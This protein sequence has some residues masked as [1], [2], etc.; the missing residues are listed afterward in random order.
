MA[1]ITKT[2]ILV[3]LLTIGGKMAQAGGG[4]APGPT[5]SDGEIKVATRV[6]PPLVIDDNGQLGGFS[7]ELWTGIAE[8]LKLRTTWSVEPNVKA[9]LDAV[10]AGRADLAIS[11]VSIT[12]DR[13]RDFD[14]SLPMMDAGL[15]ILVRG[16]GSSGAEN[17]IMGFLQLL[18]S[19]ALLVWL[20]IA[21]ILVIVPAHIL[22]F[23]ERRQTG[24]II[25]DER[26]FPGIFHAMW[27]ATSTL[28]TQAE[29]MPRHWLAR[30]LALLWMFVGIVFVAYYTAQLTASLTVQEIRGAIS[31]PA[32]L[33]GKKV[34]TTRASTAAAYLKKEGAVVE[35][36][37]QITEAYAALAAGTVDAVVFDAPILLHYAA[38]KGQGKVRVVGPVFRKEDYGI[39]FR[40][41][42][43]LR[44]AVNG[45]LLTMKEDGSYQALHDKWFKSE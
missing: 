38:H 44:R 27:W 20:G 14:F 5:L 26:Y 1:S 30:I 41:G 32:D 10:Q 31:G 18:F 43:P 22:W 33:P 15:Q 45:A 21:S 9:L 36:F 25:P 28:A 11:A 7:I 16:S 3:L 23:V 2:L 34:A 6:V 4:E 42:S 37:A 8:R 29:Q 12:A 13:E 35:E 19:P 40:P 24:G 17:P 39:A